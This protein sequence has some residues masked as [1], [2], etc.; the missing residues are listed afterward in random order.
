MI[1]L[2][3]SLD[4]SLIGF[5]EEWFWIQGAL[6]VNAPPLH[7]PHPW[8]EALFEE[9]PPADFFPRLRNE[10]AN[11]DGEVG[12]FAQEPVDEREWQTSW[13]ESFQP[14]KV[15]GFQL[16][17]EWEDE[18]G[19]PKTIRIYPGQAF[20]TGQHASTQLMIEAME[21]LK[22]FPRRVLDIGCGNGILSIV[23]ERLGADW[24]LGLDSDP[25]CE[26]N[27]L[28]HLAINHTSR[29]QLRI[30]ALPEFEHEPVSLILANITL[31]V[32][33]EVW[34]QL[35][36]RL[37]PGGVLLCSGLLESQREAALAG[38]SECGFR[39]QDVRAKDGWLMIRARA[40]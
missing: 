29:T 32:L 23:A 17:G 8:L 2:R 24:V 35:P 31:N 22:P 36:A 13:R 19:D 9:A 30:G 16:V 15:G 7:E 12:D 40:G 6:A 33:L 4:R 3:V 37:E 20:G 27:M 14:L 34:P 11:L 28:R 38:L 1:R 26:E 39:S 21:S 18:S 25:D 5:V 10:V